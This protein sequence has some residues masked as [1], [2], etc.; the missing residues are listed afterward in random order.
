MISILG[1]SHHLGRHIA[2]FPSSVTRNSG[3]LLLPMLAVLAI[4]AGWLAT[5]KLVA[6]LPLIGLIGVLVGL[7]LLERSRRSLQVHVFEHGLLYQRGRKNIPIAW[8]AV[9]CTRRQYRWTSSKWTGY[10]HVISSRRY[11]LTTHRG[12]TL[13]LT[14]S[15]AGIDELTDWIEQEVRPAVLPA[16]LARYV[17]GE[18]LQ[19][20]PFCLDTSGIQQKHRKALWAH[21]E[22]V[23]ERYGTLRVRITGQA[24]PMQAAIAQIPNFFILQEIL[25]QHQLLPQQGQ[26][27]VEH[28]A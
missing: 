3:W 1:P 20:G 23:D 13:V 26:V 9:V 17:A 4:I 8:D 24:R 5:I 12:T 7:W 28:P 14:D 2:T 27:K 25:R 10:R 16:I 21:I 6:G 11:T 19:F 18:P 15:I 22:A